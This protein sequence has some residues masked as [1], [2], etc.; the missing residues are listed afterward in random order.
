MGRV[1][2][3][4]VVVPT[5]LIHQWP[6][7]APSEAEKPQTVQNSTPRGISPGGTGEHCPP[8]ITLFPAAPPGCICWLWVEWGTAP[9]A[10]LGVGSSFPTLAGSGEH[11]SCPFWEWGAVPCPCWELWGVTGAPKCSFLAEEAADLPLPRSQSRAAIPGV[12]PGCP[13]CHRDAELPILPPALLFPPFPGGVLWDQGWVCSWKKGFAPCIGSTEIRIFCLFISSHAYPEDSWDTDTLFPL[14]CA[15]VASQG[16]V[17]I[18]QKN[19]SLCLG[20][21]TASLRAEAR[22]SLPTQTPL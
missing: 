6:G 21:G 7:E 17:F 15:W 11:L 18:W 12:T 19:L 16:C 3:T 9:Q 13:R 2:P 4:L 10:L 5:W 20:L 14:A 1:V 22:F 8:Q